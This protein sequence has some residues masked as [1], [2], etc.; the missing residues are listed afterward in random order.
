M[1]EEDFNFTIGWTTALLNGMKEH[2][3]NTYNSFENCACFHYDM[4]NMDLIIQ[5]FKGNLSGF[6]VFLCD[7]WGWKVTLCNNEKKIIIDENKDY[8]VCPVVHEMSENVPE[9]ICNCSEHFAKKMFSQVT[10]SPVNVKVIRS[11]LRDGKSCMYEI[12]F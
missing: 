11:I 5:N 6:L 8:C 7:T 9:N 12:T 4:N 10:G 1:N 2:P 3:N